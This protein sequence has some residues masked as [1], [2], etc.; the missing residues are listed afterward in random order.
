MP[1]NYFDTHVPKDQ[2]GFSKY[3]M[4]KYSEKLEGI[5]DLRVFGCFGSA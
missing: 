4:A 3:I 5:V 1:E 2:Y